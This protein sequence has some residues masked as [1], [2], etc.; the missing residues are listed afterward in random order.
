[1]QDDVG[2]YVGSE[3]WG[4]TRATL[5]H[6]SFGRM[7]MASGVPKWAASASRSAV[8]LHDSRNSSIQHTTHTLLVQDSRNQCDETIA[9]IT[10]AGKKRYRF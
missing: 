5:A 4:L 3:R 9:A 10:E 1:M 7:A 8:K 6:C 2:L